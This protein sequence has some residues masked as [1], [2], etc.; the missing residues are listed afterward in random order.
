MSEFE[1]KP[2]ITS[3]ITGCGSVKPILAARSLNSVGFSWTHGLRR[4]QPGIL[5]QQLEP[6]G[7]AMGTDTGLHA[8]QAGRHVGKPSFYLATRPLLPQHDC[9]T[10][11]EADDVERVLADIDTDH[12]GHTVKLL[13]HGVPA[14]TD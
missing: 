8:D 10:P 6:A 5:A 4:H 9:A 1:P 14:A 12:G 13:S 3:S 11:I 2:T 7:E